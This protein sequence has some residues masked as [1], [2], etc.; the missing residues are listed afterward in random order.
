MVSVFKYRY[1]ECIVKGDL[2][3]YYEVSGCYI[4]KP[5]AYNIWSQITK[6]LDARFEKVRDVNKK[7]RS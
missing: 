6:F 5:W 3:D 1:Q 2:I 7:G 4:L